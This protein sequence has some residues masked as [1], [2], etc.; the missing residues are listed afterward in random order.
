LGAIVTAAAII[1]RH[2]SD[3]ASRP[4]RIGSDDCA[5]AV[6]AILQEFG[7]TSV[8]QNRVGEFTTRAAVDSFIESETGGKGLA[9]LI[10]Q[11]ARSHGW[12]RIRPEMARDGD[13]MLVRC[14]VTLDP[15]VAIARGPMA[16]TRAKTG[17]VAIPK[18]SAVCAFSV[19][20][21]DGA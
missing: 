16:L 14:K 2:V 15:V 1:D 20:A 12:R 6:R 11:I 18:T 17:V 8:Y 9:S 13:L 4:F 10:L 7:S 21:S 19:G 3:W 5:F